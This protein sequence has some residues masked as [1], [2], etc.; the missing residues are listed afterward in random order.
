[1]C[2]DAGARRARAQ[3]VPLAHVLHGTASPRVRAGDGYSDD[4]EERKFLIKELEKKANTKRTPHGQ[5]MAN[6]DQA[7]STPASL[8]S[9]VKRSRSDSSTNQ[10][11]IN[12][13]NNASSSAAAQSL[14]HPSSNKYENNNLN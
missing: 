1:M 9:G 13:P 14:Q 8:A 12:S 7:D 11:L 10:R 2:G 4:D 5:Q 6:G 3:A